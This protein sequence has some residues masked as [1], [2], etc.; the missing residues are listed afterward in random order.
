MWKRLKVV[1]FL[2]IA[3]LEFCV[4]FS[5]DAGEYFHSQE[6][7]QHFQFSC[8]S[9]IRDLGI[10]STSNTYMSWKWSSVNVPGSDS[11]GNYVSQSLAFN[12]SR[13]ELL[14]S[15]HLCCNFFQ[16]QV[17]LNSLTPWLFIYF[18][19]LIIM[20]ITLALHLHLVK[21][22]SISYRSSV[23]RVN[24][25]HPLNVVL[26]SWWDYKFYFAHKMVWASWTASIVEKQ[27][28]FHRCTSCKGHCWEDPFYKNCDPRDTSLKTVETEFLCKE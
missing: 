15:C 11:I 4:H 23:G 24:A 25:E 20:L 8:L 6:D 18:I 28:Y 5:E 19:K 26:I 1:W 10:P 7:S 17:L 16:A 3:W 13:S 12:W 21:D 22:I 2:E 27:F 9:Q 14:V